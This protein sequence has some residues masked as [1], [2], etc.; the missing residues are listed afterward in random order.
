MSEK[1]NRSLL[2]EREIKRIERRS[3]GKIIAIVSD[4]EIYNIIGTPEYMQEDPKKKSGLL[5]FLI[6]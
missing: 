3:G 4:E 5:G 2:T 1:I 6:R